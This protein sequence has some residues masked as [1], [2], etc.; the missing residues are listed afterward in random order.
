MSTQ[1]TL[2]RYIKPNTNQ[3]NTYCISTGSPIYNSAPSSDD[4]DTNCKKEPVIL[5]G[6]FRTADRPGVDQQFE[7]DGYGNLRTFYNTGNRKVYTNDSAGTVNYATGEICFGPVNI[8]GSGGS[9][10][11]DTDI[12][13]TDSSTGLGS[14]VNPDN[15]PSGL[16]LPVQVIPSNSAVLPATTPGTIINII[17]PEISVTPIGTQFPSSIPLNS[18]TPGA[19]NVSPVVLDIPTIDNS[20]SLNTSSCFT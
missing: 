15:L 7:D 20:G 5:S 4:G 2:L 8:I 10:A 13:I 1:L 3:T 6:P 12:S 17:S 16:Q 14:V 19:F 9:N 18:L 11:D